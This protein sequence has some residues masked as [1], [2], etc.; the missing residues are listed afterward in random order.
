M[1][2]ALSPQIDF[3]R[4]VFRH[5]KEIVQFSHIFGVILSLCPCKNNLSQNKGRAQVTERPKDVIS[6]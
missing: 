6:L 4:P 2:V 1:G 3:I 5:V